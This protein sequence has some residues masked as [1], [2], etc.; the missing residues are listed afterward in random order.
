MDGNIIRQITNTYFGQIDNIFPYGFP[1]WATDDNAIK[2]FVNRTAP[3]T[4]TGYAPIVIEYENNELSSVTNFYDFTDSSYDDILVMMSQNYISPR[5]YSPKHEQMICGSN[6]SKYPSVA[7]S[8]KIAM[9]E[10]A[11]L[12]GLDFGMPIQRLHMDPAITL[13]RFTLNDITDDRTVFAVDQ[14]K[15]N[16]KDDPYLNQ[17]LSRKIM[18][19]MLCSTPYNSLTFSISGSDWEVSPIEYRTSHKLYDQY[20]FDDGPVGD[21]SIINQ[22]LQ[23]FEYQM[24]QGYFDDIIQGQVQGIFIH[25]TFYGL[26]CHI[27]IYKNGRNETVAINLSRIDQHNMLICDDIY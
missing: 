7:L 24:V 2:P 27:I 3:I 13:D 9:A 19:E 6:R 8:E 17:L 26:I 10:S 15:G 18:G 4:I 16:E 20:S 25:Q 12:T 14:V 5:Y 21:E 11:R 23:D 22:L 1:Y